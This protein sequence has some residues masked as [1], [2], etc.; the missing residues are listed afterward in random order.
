VKK[1]IFD[2]N[3]IILIKIERA[4]HDCQHNSDGVL[5]IESQSRDLKLKISLKH[6][7]CD[8]TFK[9]QPSKRSL[10]VFGKSIEKLFAVPNELYEN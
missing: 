6:F 1:L 9:L 5:S 10:A 4:F 3:K 7:R 8:G 2:I